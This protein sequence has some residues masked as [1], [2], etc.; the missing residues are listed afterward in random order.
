MFSARSGSE[1]GPPGSGAITKSPRKEKKSAG[2]NLGV[3]SHLSPKPIRA[4][5]A[6]STVD[7]PLPGPNRVRRS[8][9][10]IRGPPAL[11]F[12]RRCEWRARLPPGQRPAPQGGLL[13][14]APPGT[15]AT[16]L[17]PADPSAKT[18]CLSAAPT[19]PV[20]PPLPAEPPA[21]VWGRPADDPLAYAILLP[22]KSRAVFLRHGLS[23]V[24]PLF[25]GRSE[26]G[27][28]LICARMTQCW[29]L[30]LPTAEAVADFLR[31]PPGR[32]GGA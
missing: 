20:L 26:A 9:R 29:I 2:E 21:D 19:P 31:S 25:T 7:T 1:R 14:T 12:W 6:S 28:F 30:D 23:L 5:A 11:T 4:P 27:A 32:P 15:R 8:T 22:G 24:L 17:R 18:V 16:S 10:G 3:P 13:M